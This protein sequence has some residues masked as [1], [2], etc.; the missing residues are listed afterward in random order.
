MDT[1]PLW[2]HN[3]KRD[4]TWLTQRTGLHVSTTPDAHIRRCP[5]PGR[6]LCTNEGPATT[7]TSRRLGINPWP[8]VCFEIGED[9]KSKNQSSINGTSSPLNQVSDAQCK[10]I[11]LHIHTLENERPR[12]TGRDGKQPRRNVTVST[13]ITSP[14]CKRLFFVPSTDSIPRIS[15]TQS[16]THTPSQQD[17]R[18]ST[19]SAHTNSDA[20]PAAAP[21]RR[22]RDQPVRPRLRRRLPLEAPPPVRLAGHRRPRRRRRMRQDDGH[23]LEHT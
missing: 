15:T 3:Y 1:C 2:N 22:H 9:V 16:I 13:P 6:N 18:T 12:L 7:M 17:G 14:A 5:H 19:V 4:W 21:V 20:G 11:K 23:G 8:S 10:C